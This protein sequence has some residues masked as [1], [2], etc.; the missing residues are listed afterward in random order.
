[1]DEKT[2]LKTIKKMSDKLQ[3]KKIWKPTNNKAIVKFATKDD[4]ANF[5]NISKTDK[6]YMKK[7]KVKLCEKHEINVKN[8]R[9]FDV[10]FLEKK[11]QAQK[12]YQYQINTDDPTLQEE[13]MGTIQDQVCPLYKTDYAEQ[14]KLK[15]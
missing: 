10:K 8:K 12:D 13:A 9:G 14:I 3:V 1:M 2:I 5:L 6:N 11:L 7:F 15:R 4:C